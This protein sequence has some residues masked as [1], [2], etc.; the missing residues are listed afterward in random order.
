[1][2][3]QTELSKK[4]CSKRGC[5]KKSTGILNTKTYCER[6]YNEINPRVNR[7]RYSRAKGYY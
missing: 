2:T 1:M 3:D 6:H 5:V 4:K 7:F